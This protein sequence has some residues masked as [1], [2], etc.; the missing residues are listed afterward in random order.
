MVLIN[1]KEFKCQYVEKIT[2]SSSFKIHDPER[3]QKKCWLFVEFRATIFDHVTN[4]WLK[5]SKK[6]RILFVLFGIVKSA[7]ADIF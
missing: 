5:F 2:Q 7:E 4:C 6:S 1:K 3:Q